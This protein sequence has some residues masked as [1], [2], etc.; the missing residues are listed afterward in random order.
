MRF[1]P[2]WSGSS[3]RLTLLFAGVLLIPA[4]T[5]V[6][7]GLALLKQ[8]RELSAQRAA[9]RRQAAADRVAGAL[10]E[11]LAAAEGLLSAGTIPEG[12]VRI[13]ASAAGIRTDPPGR[14]LW[15]PAPIGSAEVDPQPFAEAELLEFRGSEEKASRLYEQMAGSPRESIRAGAL[16]R[17]ARVYRRAERIPAALDA[18]RRLAGI[19]GITIDGTPAGLVARRERCRLLAAAG[20]REELKREAAA[21]RHDLASGRWTLDHVAWLLAA[22]DV[23]RWD[24][25]PLAPAPEQQAF[26]E[27]ADWLWQEWQRAGVAAF[28]P[29]GRRAVS[30]GDMVVTVLWRR[31]SDRVE[32]LAVAPSLVRGWAESASAPARQIGARLSLADGSGRIL[33]GASKLSGQSAVRRT[34]EETHLPWTL[35]LNPGDSARETEEFRARRRLLS[36]G[37]VAIVIFLAAGSYLLWRLVQRELAVARLQ[38]DFVSAVSHEFRTPLTSL[39]HFTELLQEKDEPSPGE[40]QAFYSALARNTQRLRRLVESLLDF[41]R[42]EVGRRPYDLRTVDAGDL[43][44]QVVEEFRKEV[45]PRGFTVNLEVAAPAGHRVEADAGALT[46]ALWNLLDNAV[47]YSGDAR[48][49]WVSVN[50]HP[51]GTAISVRDEGLGIPRREQKGIFRKFVRGEQAPRL[52]IQGTGIGLAIVSHIVAAHGGRIDLQSEEGQGSRLTIVLPRGG[53][54]WR[55]S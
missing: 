26:S 52:G 12:A 8:D 47:K 5:L 19:D 20:R 15:A 32:A 4:L 36:A 16:L 27:A 22:E 45:E 9:E 38:T 54:K 50:G 11:S 44:G 37:L 42:M 41:A 29:S 2:A 51:E 17:L 46:H 18:Y 23:A 34:S 7:L 13:T 33:F 25:S 10:G 31:A 48:T 3:R 40:R 21:L 55:A 30:A 24:G 49:V 35:T 43:A 28:P 39:G 6:G 53:G 1:G 14:A